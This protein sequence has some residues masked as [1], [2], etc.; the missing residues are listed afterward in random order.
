MGGWINVHEAREIQGHAHLIEVQRS[1][2]AI[3]VHVA[4]AKKWCKCT[5]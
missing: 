2:V 4:T 3:G 5:L 1:L